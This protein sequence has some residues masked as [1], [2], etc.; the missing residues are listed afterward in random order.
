MAK[1]CSYSMAKEEIEMYPVLSQQVSSVLFNV[2]VP[3]ITENSK[4]IFLQLF[5]Y[6]L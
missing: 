3:T 4:K 5:V 1:G 6:V 2:A